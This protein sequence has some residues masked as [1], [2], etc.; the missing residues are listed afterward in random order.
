MF[1][2]GRSTAYVTT[3]DNQRAALWLRLFGVD[4][5]PVKHL[6]PRWQVNAYGRDVLAYDLDAP[7][8]NEWQVA[9]FAGYIARRTGTPFTDAKRLVDGWPLEAGGCEAVS[10]DALS[11]RRDG[12]RSLTPLPIHLLP[13]VTF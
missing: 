11:R 7:R 5:L 12:Q 2:N 1:T 4:A 9:R 10:E 6:Q 3:R 8:L 13:Q